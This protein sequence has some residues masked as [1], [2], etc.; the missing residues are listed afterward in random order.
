MKFFFSTRITHSTTW[1][2]GR[3][4]T[5]VLT[6]LLYGTSGLY[7][8]EDSLLCCAGEP[9]F[10]DGPK[11]FFSF[12]QVARNEFCTLRGIDIFQKLYNREIHIF[13]GIF[14]ILIVHPRTYRI[15]VNSP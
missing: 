14:Q 4:E 12:S 15:P 9:Y 13:M 1:S 3:V 11:S 7:Y 5:S 8:Y 2:V 10:L 6:W